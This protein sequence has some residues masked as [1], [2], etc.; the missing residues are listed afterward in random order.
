MKKVNETVRK[1]NEINKPIRRRKQKGREPRDPPLRVNEL[2]KLKTEIRNEIHALKQ[3]YSHTEEAKDLVELKIKDSK[4][5]IKF[6]LGN[7]R[8]ILQNMLKRKRKKMR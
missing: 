5:R 2:K 6:F 8:L 3:I 7:T 4:R 1:V